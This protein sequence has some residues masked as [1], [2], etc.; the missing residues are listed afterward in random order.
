[1]SAV[2]PTLTTMDTHL[3]PRFVRLLAGPAMLS[4][5]ECSEVVGNIETA[6]SIDRAVPAVA[7]DRVGEIRGLG[8]GAVRR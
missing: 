5:I 3:P 6:V 1:M 7:R 2:P 8:M 4:A